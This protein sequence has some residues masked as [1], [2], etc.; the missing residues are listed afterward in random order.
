MYES[1]NILNTLFNINRIGL[2]NKFIDSEE[3]TKLNDDFI[4]VL[5]S[6]SGEFKNFI[7]FFSL[8]D[9]SHSDLDTDSFDSYSV[10]ER[11]VT[12]IRNTSELNLAFKR[13]QDSKVLGFDT[14]EKPIFEKNQKPHPTAVVQLANES[15]C[16][17][18]QIKRI[19]N[20]LPLIKILEDESIVK[21]GMNLERDFESL[22]TNYKI[23]LKGVIDLDS[24]F[25]KLTSRT[26]IGA[27]RAFAMFLNQN[28]KK[29]KSKSRSN[30][31][32]ARLSESQILYA[33]ED[34]TVVYDIFFKLL[35]DYP[36]VVSGFPHWYRKKEI[37]LK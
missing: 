3:L 8:I 7:K 28:L 29:S 10:G 13:L 26:S 9:S 23:R 11:K 20:I 16:F 30:W 2:I 14:E 17:I 37:S 21:V 34:A 22:R 27:K 24:V 35:E 5:G 25:T 4:K 6:S 33:S 18:I 19:K 15:E 12:I 31:E 36:F 1:K 32:L